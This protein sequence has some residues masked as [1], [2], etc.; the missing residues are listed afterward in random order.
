MKPAVLA[1]ILSCL[2]APAF[3]LSCMAPDIA[4]SFNEAAS[5]EAR[6]EVVH[7]TLVFDETEL[8]QVDLT[9]QDQMPQHVDIK[10]RLS[11]KSLT[12]SGFEQVFER[13]VTL[14]A[15]CYGPWCGGAVS[16]TDYLTFLELS[17]NGY[18]LSVTPCGDYVF[19]EPSE[20]MLDQITQCFREKHCTPDKN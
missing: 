18:M 13:P 11:G 9:Q 1:S 3:A 12:K 8:P 14:R 17:E 16:D 5:A 19:P 10:A 20:A 2:T 6:Y 7:G 4:R 15:L